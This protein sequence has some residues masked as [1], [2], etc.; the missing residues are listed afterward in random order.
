MLLV[1]MHR[2]IPS[3][4]PRLN[5]CVGF[6][7]TRVCENLALQTCRHCG[8]PAIGVDPECAPVDETVIL[9][10]LSLHHYRNT[11]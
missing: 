10:T 8:G 4:L 3:V 2:F 9:L 6:A 7:R 11:Y 1:C 5:D